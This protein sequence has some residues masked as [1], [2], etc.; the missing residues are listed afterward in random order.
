MYNIRTHHIPVVFDSCMM[1]K[2]KAEVEERKMNKIE[3][4]TFVFWTLLNDC[5]TKG[6][7]C[8]LPAF[9]TPMLRFYGAALMPYV[10]VVILNLPHPYFKKYYRTS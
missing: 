8:S 5:G 9:C 7:T 4:F 10:Q 2:K 6:C 3:I 1:E